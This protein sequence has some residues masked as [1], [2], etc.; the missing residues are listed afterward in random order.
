MLR[1]FR[2]WPKEKVEYPMS[3]KT[4]EQK[5]K[6]IA[7]VRN[8]FNIFLDD[9]SGLPPSRE[10]KLHIDLIP[11]AML[12]VKSPYHLA[13]TEMEELSN[14]IKEL[15]DQGSRYFSKIDLRSRFHQ[16]RVHEDDI[17]KT[18]FRTRYGHFKF[19]VM[20]FGLKNAPVTLKDKLCNVPVLALPYGPQDFVVYYDA[21]CQGLGCVLMQRDKVIA[22][23]SQQLKSHEKNYTTHDLELGVVV[24]VLKIWRHYLAFQQLDCKIHYHLGKENIVADALTRKEIIK[25]RRVQAMY[26]IIQSGIKSKIL[27]AHNE[28]SKVVNAPAEMLQGIDKHMELLESIF[29]ST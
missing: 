21:S 17:P 16:L 13:P 2:E 24:F 5:L 26:M 18:T 7:I 15:Q 6:D 3:A 9:L 28:A 23:A 12:V 14:Q 10:I 29:Y 27:G 8:F 19:I 1:V 22:Y 11:G 4:E 25:P 20:P